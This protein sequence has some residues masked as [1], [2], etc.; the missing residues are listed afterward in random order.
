MTNFASDFRSFYA[1]LEVH[2]SLLKAVCTTKYTCSELRQRIYG[3]CIT[4]N[5][6]LTVAALCE[7]LTQS[8]DRKGAVGDN[9]LL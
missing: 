3:K 1:H 4:T 7:R 5:R 9:T 8:R 6:F 2:S